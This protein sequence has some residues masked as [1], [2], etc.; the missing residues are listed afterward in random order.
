MVKILYRVLRVWVLSLVWHLVPKT[1][2]NSHV[3]LVV[4]IVHHGV[5]SD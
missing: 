2:G 1:S 5:V 3:E 4:F